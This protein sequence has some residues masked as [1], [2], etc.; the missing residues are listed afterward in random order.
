M[1]VKKFWGVVFVSL[2]AIS[3]LAAME[4]NSGPIDATAPLAAA[5]RRVWGPAVHRSEFALVPNGLKPRFCTDV[6][7]P[8]PW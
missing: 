3:C 4:A 5:E 8:G 1:A 7:P 6:Q 2:A